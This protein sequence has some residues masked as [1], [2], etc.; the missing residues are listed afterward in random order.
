MVNEGLFDNGSAPAS[1]SYPNRRD[2]RTVLRPF[3]DPGLFGDSDEIQQ[4]KASS[5][6][7]RNLAAN[8]GSQKLAG[9]QD[10][11]EESSKYYK[12]FG[13]GHPEAE[14]IEK[15]EESATLSDIPTSSTNYSRPRTVAA[16]YDPQRGVLTV[17]FRDGTFYNYYDVSFNEWVAFSGSYSK[18]RPWLNRRGRT[19]SADGLFVGKPRGPANVADIDPRI[20]EQ[21]YRVARA[22]QIVK[23]PKAHRYHF[24]ESKYDPQQGQKVGNYRRKGYGVPPKR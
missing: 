22:Q 2:F 3:L 14:G 15:E 10:A 11:Y 7:Q 8:Q 6:V 12:Y 9:F 4:R 17:V 1:G 5:A 13:T 19:Q 16:G 23:K 20:R 18:G 24:N 21:L